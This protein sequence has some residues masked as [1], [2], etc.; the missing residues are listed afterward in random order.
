MSEL[1]KVKN[2]HKEFG[3]NVVL[4]DINLSVDKGEVVV[5][6]GPS[7][8]GKSTFLRCLNGL[9]EIQG[10]VITVDGL[11]VESGK[12]EITKLRQKIG[13][14]FQSYELFPHLSVIDNLTLA[15]TKVQKR[16]KE[17][18]IK[19][20]TELLDRVGLLDKKD[21]FPRQLSGGQ[22]Q[23][24]A[25][26]RALLMHPEVLLFDEVTAALDPEMVHEVLETMLRLAK[27]GS[28]MLIVTHE[29]SFAEAVADR[30][31]FFDNGEIVEEAEDVKGFFKE[32]KTER[33][34]KFLRTFEYDSALY[35]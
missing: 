19:E 4:K 18:V 17:D 32:P 10:G 25:I 24:V 20:A 5:I 30:I 29:M 31:L 3:A 35:I 8:C 14:V 28:T 27:S 23:R 12:K 7:G 9:E 22:K 13:M 2:L 15:P 34:R 26:V 33:A 16:K 6:I 21:Y 1:L 11:P